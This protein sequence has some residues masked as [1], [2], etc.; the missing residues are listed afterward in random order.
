MCRE[1]QAVLILAGF[2]GGLD[3]LRNG[4]GLR[5]TVR[6]TVWADPVTCETSIPGVFAGGDAVSGPGTVI[7]ALALGRRC[8]ESADRFLDGRDLREDRELPLPPKLLW[9]LEVDEE[10]R[11]RRERTPVMLKPFNEALDE[12]GTMEE[13]ERCLDCECGLCVKDCEFLAQHCE[14]PKDLAR[15]VKKGL[16]PEEARRMVYSCNICSLCANVCPEDLN[17][18]AMLIEARRTA[19]EGGIGPLPV[20]KPIVGYFNAGVSKTFSMLMS[21]PGRARSKRLFFTGC[22]LPAT[23]PKHTITAYDELRRN[24]SGTGVLMYCCGAPVELLGMDKELSGA[25]EAI[26]RQAEKVGAEEL[27]TACPDCTHTLK[28]SVPELKVTT[29][30]EMLDGRWEPPRLREGDVISIHDSCKASHEPGLQKAVRGL[31]RSGGSGIEDV[32]YR[33]ELARCCG[34][35]G[36]IFPVDSELSQKIT[37]RRA[38]ESPLPMITYC[39]GCRMA[40][41]GSG[42]ESIHI[43]D[44]LLTPDWRKKAQAKPP[45]TIGRYLNRLRTKWAFKRLRPLGAD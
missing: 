20:H 32:E 4:S 31:L 5:K 35:G 18:G 8:A 23:A 15:R 40:L 44:Y 26:L 14:S 17:T 1:H 22:G 10:E 43:L 33:G 27:I 39:A 28:E 2:E 25:T 24:Y 37:R 34:F 11:R 13:A 36:M 42:K 41:A 30:W 45:G 9:T 21:E 29:V 16:E 38:D 6:D 12:A 7:Q 3:L 19:V